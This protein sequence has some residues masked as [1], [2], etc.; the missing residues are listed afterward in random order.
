MERSISVGERLRGRE[1][2]EGED[3]RRAECGDCFLLRLFFTHAVHSTPRGQHHGDCS[4][5]G[6]QEAHSKAPGSRSAHEYWLVSVAAIVVV[7]LT[8]AQ[9][10]LPHPAQEVRRAE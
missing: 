9:P 6:R 5:Q 8:T 2:G 1:S 3:S 10:D 4:G 7:V